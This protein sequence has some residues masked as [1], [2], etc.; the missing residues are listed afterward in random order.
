[1]QLRSDNPIKSYSIL[2]ILNW[3]VFPP[4]STPPHFL[5]DCFPLGRNLVYRPIPSNWHREKTAQ[6]WNDCKKC[7]GKFP[8]L[9][10]LGDKKGSTVTI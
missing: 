5:S 4:L 10:P 6:I 3:P 2:N 1:M 8:P 7:T 9:L